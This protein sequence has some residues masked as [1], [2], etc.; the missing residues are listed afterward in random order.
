MNGFIN[1]IEAAKTIAITGHLRP[2][3]D[4]VGSCLGLYNYII[5]NYKD[6]IVKVYLQEFSP[7]FMFLNGA[8]AISHELDDMI[9]DLCIVLDSGDIDRTADFIKYFDSAKD[10]AVVD[11]HIS[12]TG[13]GN[14][15][16]V[17]PDA[18]SASEAICD[19]IDIA[20]ISSRGAECFYLGIVHDTGV[21]K[22]SNTTKR[23][24]CLAGELIEK[25]ARPHFVIDETFYKKTYVQNQLL[26]RAL[27]ESFL[28]MDGQ[29]IVSVLKKNVF[30][31]YN[32]TSVDCDG[33]VD[34]LRITAGVDVAVF[35]Y[36]TAVDEYKVSMRS[37]VIVNVSEIATMFGGGGHIRAA[38]V[39]I[40]GN[41]Y[42]IIN[43]ITKQISKQLNE[44]K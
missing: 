42:D 17:K 14:F 11:H 32:A 27:L 3:G 28:M 15:C 7:D 2:D 10:T 5:D 22:H 29:V 38:G 26:G 25:G 30:D 6:K 31:F 24:M 4:C 13:Y 12:N 18:S 35:I 43:N 33:I 21:F 19:L 40:K 44:A 8:N 1:K 9:Y 41:I 23:A 20:K 16:Y 34:Q 36:E 37:N 39:S